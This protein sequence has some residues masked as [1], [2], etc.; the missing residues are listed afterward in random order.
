MIDRI[1]LTNFKCFEALNLDL[2]PLTLL[3]GFNAGGKSTATQTLLLLLLNGPVVS[4]GTPADVLN[5]DGGS[6][7]MSLGASS[8]ETEATWYF[9]V[10]DDDRR[11]LRIAYAETSGSVARLSPRDLDGIRPQREVA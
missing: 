1:T 2:A 7:Q 4:L 9:E 10:P 8:G 5:A 6:K 3:T 11:L